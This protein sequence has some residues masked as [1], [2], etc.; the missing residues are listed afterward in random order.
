VRLGDRSEAGPEWEG[1]VELL[2]A[3]DEQPVNRP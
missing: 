1:E 2:D 3:T